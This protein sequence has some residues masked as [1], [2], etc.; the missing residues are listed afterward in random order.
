MIMMII[1]IMITT[2]MWMIIMV[3]GRS[4]KREEKKDGPSPSFVYP[5]VSVPHVSQSQ[6]RIAVSDTFTIEFIDSLVLMKNKMIVHFYISCK[7]Y[8]TMSKH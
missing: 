6:L 2:I 7:Y 1:I 8:V 3:K 4:S 5:I